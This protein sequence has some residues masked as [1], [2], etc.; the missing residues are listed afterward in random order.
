MKCHSV[1]SESQKH[2]LKC[3]HR[4]HSPLTQNLRV[5]SAQ[6][7]FY[8]L[9]TASEMRSLSISKNVGQTAAKWTRVKVGLRPHLTGD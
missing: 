3:A 9:Q 8:F 7:C 4:C 5:L 2:L 1:R 6:R